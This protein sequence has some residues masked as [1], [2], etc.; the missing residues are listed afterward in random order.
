MNKPSDNKTL[1]CSFQYEAVFF[2]TRVLERETETRN[3]RRM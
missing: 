3:Y 2:Y 1:M